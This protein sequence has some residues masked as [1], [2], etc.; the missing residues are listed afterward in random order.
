MENKIKVRKKL[1]IN[2][3]L[4]LTLILLMLNREIGA[5]LLSHGSELAS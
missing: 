3:L 5:K 2:S 4:F 1:K